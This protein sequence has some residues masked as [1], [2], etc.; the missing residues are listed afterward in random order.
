MP[1]KN[2]ATATSGKNVAAVPKS[3]STMI[4]PTGSAMMAIALR[5]ER[6]FM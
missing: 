5:N 1:P 6:V 2:I 4:N 3:G